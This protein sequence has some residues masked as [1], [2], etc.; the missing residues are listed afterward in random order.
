[1]NVLVIDDDREC[2][3]SLSNA[4]KMYGYDVRAFESPDKAVRAYNPD[5][6][7]IVITDF[8]LPGMTAIDIIK[9][10]HKKKNTTPIIVTSGDEEQ[11]IASLCLEAG[12]CAFFH[13]PLDVHQI[14]EIMKSI[15][16]E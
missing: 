3:D 7:D 14:I 15:T 2:G 12:A 1:M 6:I 13:K 4:L 10:I 5:T 16:G 9:K 8:H 11:E